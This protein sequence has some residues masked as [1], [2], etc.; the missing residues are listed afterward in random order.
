MKSS[1]KFCVVATSEYDLY[2][3]DPRACEWD[4]A[5]GHAILI[6]AGGGT[7]NAISLK[8]LTQKCREITLN[9]IK[10]SVKKNTSIYDIPYFVTDNSEA[11][12]LYKWSPKKNIDDIIFDT[13]LWMKL[14]FK[15]IKLYFR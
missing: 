2:V 12:N 6:N 10:F 1:L 8:E 13:F 3:A 14:N 4:I 11:K 7:K 5:A 15:K 9:S